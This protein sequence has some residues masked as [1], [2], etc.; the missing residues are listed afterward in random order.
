MYDLLIVG[1]GPAGI[2]TA[3]EAKHAGINRVLLLER[4]PSHS[5]TI[6]R[7]YVPGKRVDTAWKGVSAACEGLMCILPGTRETVL[8]TLEEFIRRYDLDIRYSQEVHRIARTTDGFET[9]TAAGTRLR[10]TFSTCT[11]PIGSPSPIAGR[12]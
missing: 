8:A 2:S 4:A 9:W 5:Y 11:R 1:A 3:V 12:P 6:Q 10:S 7:L